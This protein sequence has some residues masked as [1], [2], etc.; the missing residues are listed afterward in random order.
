MRFKP[1]PFCGGV[2]ELDGDY[3][4]CRECGC[5]LPILSNWN[6]RM[7]DENVVYDYKLV[8]AIDENSTH[9]LSDTEFDYL[10]N[11]NRFYNNK[12]KK[13]LVTPDGKFLD[14][15]D[16]HTAVITGMLGLKMNKQMNDSDFDFAEFFIIYALFLG[17]IRVNVFDNQ[18]AIQYEVVHKDTLKVLFEN[19]LNL[20]SNKFIQITIEKLSTKKANICDDLSSAYEFLLGESID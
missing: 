12:S 7:L 20:Y 15:Q 9:H 6:I 13:F 1:C 11:L 4:V 10:Y 5:K 14:L 16:E 8:N 3:V 18:L 17:Y 19:L 2:A